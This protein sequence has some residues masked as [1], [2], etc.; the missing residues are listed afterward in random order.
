MDTLD[1]PQLETGF[2]FPDL[3][4]WVALYDDG[5]RLFEYD[6][7]GS[8]GFT[9]VDLSRLRVFL[10]VPTQPGFSTHHVQIAPSKGQRP[11]F[12][13]RRSIQLAQDGSEVEKKTV[14]CLGS[15]STVQGVNVASYLFLF[16][17][18]SSLLTDDYQAV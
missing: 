11:I 15:Q 9:E 10:L 5:S 13:R 1:M 16:E 2:D 17:D 3:W 8:H 12:F 4:T 14:H 18:G 6:E 7:T